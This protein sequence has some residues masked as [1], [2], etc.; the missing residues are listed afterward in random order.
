MVA[1]LHAS[2]ARI[3]FHPGHAALPQLMHHVR[4]VHAPVQEPQQLG[5][6]PQVSRLRVDE[7]VQRQL[8]QQAMQH[9][10][11][12]VAVGLQHVVLLLGP[13]GQVHQLGPLLLVRL[14]DVGMQLVQCLGEPHLVTVCALRLPDVVVLAQECAQV[15]RCA[16]DGGRHVILDGQISSLGVGVEGLEAKVAANTP[17]SSVHVVL[18]LCGLQAGHLDGQVLRQLIRQP[19]H[20]RLLLPASRLRQAALQLCNFLGWRCLFECLC[21]FCH[22]HFHV[23]KVGRSILGDVVH[24]ER[25]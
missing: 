5:G 3:C 2:G 25:N 13:P 24:A 8:T 15:V 19:V 22:P 14:E 16:E 4:V 1:Q 11:V 12:V 17:H 10:G 7:Q 23:R 18:P 21:L 9:G 6:V 20:V